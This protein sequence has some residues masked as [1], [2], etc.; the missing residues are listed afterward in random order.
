MFTVYW[1][2]A[3]VLCALCPRAVHV[4]YVSGP[5]ESLALCHTHFSWHTHVDHRVV[6]HIIWHFALLDV[7]FVPFCVFM[8]SVQCI[9][10]IGHEVVF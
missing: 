2:D 7:Y 8:A 3:R 1:D 5:R 10:N 6:W 9:V 4:V